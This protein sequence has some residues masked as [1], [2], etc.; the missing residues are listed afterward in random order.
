MKLVEFVDY[1][2]NPEK[3]ESFY[4]EKGLNV[5]S[6]S[7]LIYMKQTINIDSEIVFFEM[8]ETDDE[9]LFSKDGIEYLQLFPISH[10]VELIESDLDLKDKGYTNLQ[11]A[12]RLV[13]YRIHDA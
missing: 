8:E 10:A 12:N 13:E 4:E 9:V 6:E 1:L 11:I 3:L 5:E 7:L 2:V